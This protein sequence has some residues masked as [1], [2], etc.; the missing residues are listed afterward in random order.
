MAFHF[1]KLFLAGFYPPR[2]DFDTA[3]IP[4]AVFHGLKSTDESSRLFTAAC[5]HRLTAK[6]Q[7]KRKKLAEC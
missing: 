3:E 4:V 1:Y 5:R 2:V 7:W 6:V